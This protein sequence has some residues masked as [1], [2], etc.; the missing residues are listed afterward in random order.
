MTTVI[1]LKDLCVSYQ[2]TRALDGVTLEFGR[3]ATGLLGPNGAGKSTLLKALLGFVRTEAGSIRIFEH[4]MPRDAIAIRQRLGY[5]PEREISSPKVSAVSFLTYCGRIFGM[6]RVD[7]LERAHEVLNYVKLGD[8]RYR[9]METYSTG[10]LQRVKLAQ[11]ILHDP[12]LLLLDEPTNGL[13]PDG[14]IEVLNLVRDIASR[15]GI[16]VIVSSHL[17]PDVQHVCSRVVMIDKGRVVQSGDIQS[18][19]PRHANHFEIRFRDNDGACVA[20]LRAGGC[21][22]IRLHPNNTWLVRCPEDDGGKIIFETALH[23]DTQVRHFLP[24]RHTLESVFLHAVGK[25]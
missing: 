24:A 16:S 22:C 1:E 6:S 17:L 20:A 15:P 4:S 14:R 9:N 8:S 5:M 11:A 25:E 23:R 3:G 10:M 18:L 2:Q 19:T 13:D 7:A 21:S 12:K